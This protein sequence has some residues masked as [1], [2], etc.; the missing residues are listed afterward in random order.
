M[1]KGRGEQR[2]MIGRAHREVMFPL[3]KF[4]VP[5]RVC[6]SLA[7]SM[8][9]FG[10]MRRCRNIRFMTGMSMVC[11]VVWTAAL[12]PGTHTHSPGDPHGLD[13]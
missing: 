6:T 11:V 7:D 1:H 13:A 5:L 10:S 2:L 8:S 3:D 12:T 9:R 4:P